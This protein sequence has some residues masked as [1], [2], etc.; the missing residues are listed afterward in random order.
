MSLPR[1]ALVV[2]LP[3]LLLLGCDDNA[4]LSS[5]TAERVERVEMHDNEFDPP[6]VEVATGATVTWAF[7]DGGVP[8]DVVGDGFE[9]EV[10]SDGTFTHT[11][12]V[13]GTYD[14]TCTLHKGMDG[15]AIVVD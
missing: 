14:Y 3:L 4:D 7:T 9:S 12:D 10:E 8:H 13:A 15:R 6:V 11:F 1:A 2:V 5:A